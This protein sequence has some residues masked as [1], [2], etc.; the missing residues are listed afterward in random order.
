[1]EFTPRILKNPPI[2]EAIYTITFKEPI[3]Q[4]KLNSFLE[5]KFVKLNFPV[6]RHGLKVG[7]SISQGDVSIPGT[8]TEGYTL[9]P[10]INSR[11]NRLIHVRP[12]FLSYHNLAKYDGWTT[13]ITELK[14]LWSEFCLSVGVGI[15]SDVR[16]RNINNIDIP[17]PLE[18]GFKEYL[19]LLPV[20]PP[21]INPSIENFFIQL[22]TGN[23]NKT[24]KATISETI[25]RYD[26][27]RR[28]VTLLLDIAVYKKDQFV[29]SENKMWQAF[30]ELRQFKDDIFFSCITDKTLQI[31][32]HE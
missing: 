21:G 29:C 23:Q 15:L 11:R 30:D 17:L 27:T 31:F 19:Q 14:D 3:P 1:M 6:I 8:S 24:L 28:I 7:I 12:T 26:Q 13:M 4:E 20:V 22:N 18:K 9:R 25:A 2:K 16:V 5:S 32:D 10:E